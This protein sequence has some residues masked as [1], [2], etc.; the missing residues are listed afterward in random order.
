MSA[1]QPLT[2]EDRWPWLQA[3]A[4]EIDRVCTG[5]EHARDRLFGAEASLSRHSGAWPDDVRIV[6]LDGT[7]N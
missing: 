1:G 7:A 6:Y 5:G 4:D 3:I 2:D